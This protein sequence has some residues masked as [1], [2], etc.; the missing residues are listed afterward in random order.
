MYQLAGNSAQENKW[1]ARL[2]S[3]GRRQDIRRLQLNEL[4][5]NGLDKLLPF[6]GMWKPLKASQ[7]ERMLAL[8][9]PEVRKLSNVSRLAYRFHQLIYRYLRRIH[10]SWSRSFEGQTASCVDFSSVQVVE[11][12]MPQSSL[13]DRKRIAEL[14]DSGQIFP[15]VTGAEE[16]TTLRDSLLSTPGRIISLN[17]LIKDT[18]FLDGPAKAL[19]RLCPPR[20]KGSFKR[21]M[22]RQWKMVGTERS[23]EIQRSE[24][25]FAT[26]QR[27]ANSFSVCMMQLWLFALRH[28][29]P[30][31]RGSKN[32]W[33]HFGWSTEDLSLRRLAVLAERLG[34]QSD[35]ITSLRSENLSQNIAKGFMESLCREDFYRLEERR[36]QSMSNQL[37]NILRNLPTY[38]EEDVKAAQFTTN[39][40]EAAARYRYNKPTQEE[41]DEQRKYLFLEPLFG[42]DQAAAEYTT[43]LGVTREILRCFFADD[44]REMISTQLQHLSGEPLRSTIAP[45]QRTSYQY[46]SPTETTEISSDLVENQMQT[47]SIP[48]D[49]DSSQYSRSPGEPTVEENSPSEPVDMEPY[50]SGTPDPPPPLAAGF[51]D[52][53]CNCP[54]ERKNYISVRRKVPEILKI[55]YQS[56]R[57]VI[58]VFLFE[59][60]I[61]YKFNTTGGF[62]LR[63]LL[64]DLSRE[65]IFIVINGFGIG[66]P[67]INR[68][69]EEALKERLL[70]VGKRNNPAQG[71]NEVGMMSLDR[72]Q[73]YVLNYDIHLGKRKA[74]TDDRSTKRIAGPRRESSEEL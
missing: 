71:K 48:V 2:S 61:Y 58:V 52:P 27:N 65:H 67:D 39:S 64:Q 33:R 34:F 15:L 30:Q 57:E 51:E 69:Y 56:Q 73:E 35:Q 32:N 21:A 29:V 25:H 9:S 5:L 3:E 24:H 37:R 49:Q 31:Q 10:E 53:S 7:I 47:E 4:F 26:I 55:W 6:V 40:P 42:P 12:L 41:Y 13:V 59:S 72:L 46:E 22:L 20:F 45:S 17:T 60:R 36:V 11:G 70:L 74:D 63:S 38:S 18:L 68:T 43:S 44:I 54:L 19:R 66:M 1:R 16:R 8:K 62:N 14:V 28:F 23:L 50:P